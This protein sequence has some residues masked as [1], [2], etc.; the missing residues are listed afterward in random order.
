MARLFTILSDILRK[1]VR[2]MATANGQFKK[3]FTP[4]WE[5][6]IKNNQSVLNQKIPSL[7]N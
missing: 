5:H 4:L 1:Q 6:E 3:G 2:I 7:F